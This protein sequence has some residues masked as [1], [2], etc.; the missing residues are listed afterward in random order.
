MIVIRV[1]NEQF[2]ITVSFVRKKGVT[3]VQPRSV[4]I[5]IDTTR[6]IGVG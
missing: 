5:D 6:C 2:L 1:L 3:K 4:G